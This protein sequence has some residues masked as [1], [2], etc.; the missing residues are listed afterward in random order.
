MPAPLPLRRGPPGRHREAPGPGPEPSTLRFGFSSSMATAQPPP[1]SARPGELPLRLH[2]LPPRFRLRLAPRLVPAPN[3]G[4]C[5]SAPPLR[6][7]PLLASLPSSGPP[8]S[9]QVTLRPALLLLTYPRPSAPRPGAVL[10]PARGGLSAPHP[11]DFS[12]LLL[13]ISFPPS[14]L[15]QRPGSGEFS[16]ACV[17]VCVGEVWGEVSS[18]WRGCE[19]G[20]WVRRQR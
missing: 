20:G 9:S 10:P 19:E 3:L 5:P 16:G 17:S 12:L 2:L 8:L 14:P 13:E 15:H 11:S 18:G 7:P 1:P 4:P 6:A